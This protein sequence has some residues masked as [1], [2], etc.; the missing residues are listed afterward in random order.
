[1][2]FEGKGDFQDMVAVRARAPATGHL[3]MVF[4]ILFIALAATLIGPVASQ[5]ASKGPPPFVVAHT[6][7]QSDTSGGKVYTAKQY[8]R[9]YRS[10]IRSRATYG[11]SD[12][13]ASQSLDKGHVQAMETLRR[14]DEYRY[15]R[16]VRRQAVDCDGALAAGRYLSNRLF[17]SGSEG[18]FGPQDPKD[19]SI[20]ETDIIN[21]MRPALAK[22]LK[23]CVKLEDPKEVAKART[24]LLYG[25]FFGA[26]DAMWNPGALPPMTRKLKICP[27][28]TTRSC[29]PERLKGMSCLDYLKGQREILNDEIN[30][31][32]WYN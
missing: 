15:A 11:G 20:F 17:E 8:S 19:L 13:S 16:K 2:R 24:I 26:V 4:G 14:C 23:R 32:L 6:C 7:R 12:N 9:A 18:V 22:C 29:T 28:S 1:V 5:A 21:M 30:E 27:K 31:K 10:L 25:R 3:S